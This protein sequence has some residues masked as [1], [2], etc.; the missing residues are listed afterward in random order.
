MIKN[1]ITV[2]INIDFI[3]FSF[4]QISFFLPKYFNINHNNIVEKIKHNHQGTPNPL[5]ILQK[6]ILTPPTK[7]AYGNCVFT[8]L[9]W[10]QPEARDD[11]I[12]VSDIGEQWSPHTDPHNTEEIEAY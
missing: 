11:N 7:K 8:W 1:D 6:I 4:Y 10:S 3:K 9:R 12:V 5:G 2:V